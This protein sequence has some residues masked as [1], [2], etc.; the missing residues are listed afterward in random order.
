MSKHRG[1]TFLMPPIL[2]RIYRMMKA[3]PLKWFVA[4]ELGNS[5]SAIT[6]LNTLKK[7][8]LIEEGRVRYYNGRYRN[9][10][11]TTRG[12]RYKR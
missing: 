3:K 1:V 5:Y 10:E 6:Y 4:K 8:D 2:L 7:L 9:T 12:W 11:Q